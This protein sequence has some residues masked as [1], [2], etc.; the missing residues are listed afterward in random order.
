LI[1]QGN[2]TSTPTTD[3]T[4][5]WKTYRNEEYGFEFKYPPDWTEKQSFGEKGSEYLVVFGKEIK[6]SWTA[7]PGDITF[8]R[9]VNYEKLPFK[10]FLISYLSGTQPLPYDPEVRTQTIETNIEKMD[11]TNFH[12]YSALINPNGAIYI[13]LNPDVISLNIY[14]PDTKNHKLIFDQIRSTFQFTE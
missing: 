5:N 1:P 2:L 8:Q 14:H 13:F 4:A 12:S 6:D 11:N 7:T 9:Y 3:E 10:E